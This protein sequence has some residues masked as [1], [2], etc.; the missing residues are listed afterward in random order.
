MKPGAIESNETPGIFTIFVIFS[1]AT[2]RRVTYEKP[3]PR[4]GNV[5]PICVMICRVCI[6]I[7]NRRVIL[8]D[9]CRC[10]VEKPP[11]R[12]KKIIENAVT[13]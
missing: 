6:T 3:P 5:K 2:R 13:E 8:E 1:V 11:K 10:C 4:A 9:N 12:P 7:R